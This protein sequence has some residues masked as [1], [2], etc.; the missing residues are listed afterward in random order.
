M[1]AASL[2]AWKGRLAQAALAPAFVEAK[3]VGSPPAEAAGAIEVCLR[4]G[5]RLRVGGGFDARVLL[6]LVTVLEGL[7]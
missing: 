5:R 1:A 7:S 2:Y 6:E 4:G 3:V